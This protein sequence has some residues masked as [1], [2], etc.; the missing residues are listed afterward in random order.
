MAL[1]ENI[2]ICRLGGFVGSNPEILDS[3]PPFNQ[4]LDEKQ[5][6]EIILKSIPE[7]SQPGSYTVNKLGSKVILSYIY[8]KFKATRKAPGVILHRS[9]LSCRRNGSTCSICRN[10]SRRSLNPSKER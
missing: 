2:G 6:R 5:Q 3:Y 4:S 1:V 9:P 10:Y 7:G 8:T